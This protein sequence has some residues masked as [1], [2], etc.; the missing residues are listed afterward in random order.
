[1]IVAWM[2]LREQ[3]TRFREPSYYTRGERPKNRIYTIRFY[4]TLHKDSLYRELSAITNDL[5]IFDPLSGVSL[6]C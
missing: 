5:Y 2:F 4:Y 3:K 6:E 1:M